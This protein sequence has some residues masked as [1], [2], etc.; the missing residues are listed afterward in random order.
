MFTHIIFKMS[1]TRAKPGY[2]SLLFKINFFFLLFNLKI[3][4]DKFH[5]TISQKKNNEESNK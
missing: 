4:H 3:C 2:L 5:F 1:K